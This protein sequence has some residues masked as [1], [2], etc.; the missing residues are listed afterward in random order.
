MSNR[1]FQQKPR[2]SGSD[3]DE[4]LNLNDIAVVLLKLVAIFLSLIFLLRFPV[5]WIKLPLAGML[6]FFGWKWI[7]RTMRA[8]PAPRSRM[9]K[10]APIDRPRL[11]TS[12]STRRHEEFSS[13][14]CAKLVAL[15]AA[16]D[17]AGARALVEGLDGQEF[18]EEE[19]QEIAQLARNYV[20]VE[21]E[22]TDLGARISVV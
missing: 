18:P 20:E 15:D 22:P 10:D 19:A 3:R 5:L 14:V 13:D 2:K 21:L 12:S 9:V 1:S 17:F 11:A 4:V 8:T 7:M 6:L 16:G